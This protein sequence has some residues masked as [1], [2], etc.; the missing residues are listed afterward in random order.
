MKYILLT[1]CLFLGSCGI[2]TQMTYKNGYIQNSGKVIG[3]Y[4][5]GH[6]FDKDRN[7]KGYYA[8]GFIYDN[9]HR[10]MRRYNNGF[11]KL[12]PEAKPRK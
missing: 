11:V 1:V 7:I 6:I 2:T 5:N 12:N 8:N 4:A 3:N 10:M 9:N